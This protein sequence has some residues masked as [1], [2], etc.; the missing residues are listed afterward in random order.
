MHITHLWL[1]ADQ[2]HTVAAL[3]NHSYNWSIE[4]GNAAV[5]TNRASNGKMIVEAYRNAREKRHSARVAK[6][7]KEIEAEMALMEEVFE[8]LADKLDD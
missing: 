8:A 4:H 5:P 7:A 6:M 1:N 2:V 3:R